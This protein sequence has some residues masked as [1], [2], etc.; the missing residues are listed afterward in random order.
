MTADRDRNG[1]ADGSVQ[2]VRKSAE[3]LDC[4]SVTTPRLQASEIVRRTGLPS[5]T[6]ARIL[7]TLVR[8][9]LLQ[10][11]GTAYGIG[12][13]VIG[14]SAAADAASDLIT[15]ARP[16]V[17]ALRD[18]CGECCGLQ[19]RQG[20]RRVT[21]IWAQSTHSIVYR[22]HVG[23]VMPLQ[24]SAAGKVFM[25]FDPDVL[26]LVLNEGLTARTART[27]VDPA[28]LLGQLEEVREQGWAFSGEELEP[29]LNSLAAPVRSGDGRVIAAVSVGGPSHRLTP[30]RA[31]D[32]AAQAIDCASAIAD[33]RM[34]RGNGA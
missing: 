27:V 11:E 31:K 26:A 33:G 28:V 13:R 24:P 6:V 7:R 19:V 4:F 1:A 17:T 25:A 16:L 15:A 32:L 3:I 2:V 21:V 12:L 29:G 14:W 20:G 30:A 5:S 22:G 9:N 8:E 18:R 34:W 23:Q 10:R